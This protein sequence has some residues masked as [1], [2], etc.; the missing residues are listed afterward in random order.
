MA[1]TC[2]SQNL[3]SFEDFLSLEGPCG[4][5]NDLYGGHSSEGKVE[6]IVANGL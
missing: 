1:F 3:V 4:E 5:P 6:A 2:P